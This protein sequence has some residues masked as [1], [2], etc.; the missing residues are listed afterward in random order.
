[1]TER[2]T[3]GSRDRRFGNLPGIFRR[4]LQRNAR[5]LSANSGAYRPPGAV[6][7]LTIADTT[8]SCG[9]TL[10]LAL[11]RMHITPVAHPLIP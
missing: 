11:V 8:H 4:H 7:T 3:I 10:R 6:D 5:L 1:M 2:V 9:P